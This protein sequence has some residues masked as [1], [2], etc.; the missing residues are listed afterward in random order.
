MMRELQCRRQAVWRG[1][2]LAAYGVASAE[3]L[4]KSTQVE[5]I[6][7]SGEADMFT[8]HEVLPMEV[9][10]VVH[11]LLLERTGQF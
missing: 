2:V 3:E 4:E 5:P 9:K 11:A 1:V 10:A 7:S 8:M 6:S